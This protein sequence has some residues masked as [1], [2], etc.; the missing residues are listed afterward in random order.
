MEPVTQAAEAAAAR[1]QAAFQ[2]AQAA[3]EAAILKECQ[4][5][6]AACAALRAKNVAKAA[7]R[8]R[9]LEE[10]QAEIASLRKDIEHYEDQSDARELLQAFRK[11]AQVLRS[12]V[13]T[14][15]EENAA[16]SG[17]MGEE[18]RLAAQRAALPSLQQEAAK[19][20]SCAAE[21]EKGEKRSKL[22]HRCLEEVRGRL[23]I[24]KRRKAEMEQEILE[25]RPSFT[26]LGRQIEAAERER[27]WVH[28]ELDK[29]R[30]TSTGLRAEICQLREVRG[31]I[32]SVP[33][34]ED[35]QLGV[36]S[37]VGS[38]AGV[39][40]FATLQRRLAAVAPQ[41][42]PLC[43]RARAEMEELIQCCNRL[44]QRQKRLQQVAH[45]GIGAAAAGDDLDLGSI[46]V[47]SA[48]VGASRPQRARST[49]T[50]ISSAR[51]ASVAVSGTAS[52]AEQPGAGRGQ[53]RRASDLARSPLS[54]E[55]LGTRSARSTPRGSRAQFAS[56][57]A[58]TLGTHRESDLAGA[59]GDKE[60][61]H[62]ACSSR[63]P[64]CG[65]TFM[66]DSLFCRHCGQ[67]RELD[68]D[69]QAGPA[70]SSSS[71]EPSPRMPPSATPL[72]AN[73]SQCSQR[74]GQQA[75]GRTQADATKGYAKARTTRGKSQ[76]MA[77]ARS[78]PRAIAE[79]GRPSSS[80][81]V[82]GSCS[83]GYGGPQGAGIQSTAGT[84]H[85]LGL[86]VTPGTS[87]CVRGVQLVPDAKK[88]GGQKT[89]SRDRT[90]PGSCPVA[91]SAPSW[92]SP[93]GWTLRGTA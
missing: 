4:E 1:R 19:L 13:E 82:A 78:S 80:A 47:G 43:S 16:L 18:R 66:A 81:S 87:A 65:N 72:V 88:P 77:E 2:Q 71:R 45:G 44:E 57:S 51:G 79:P 31:A 40:R 28:G 75:S 15:R 14:L 17:S 58:S 49:D 73:G 91:Q 12:Q 32:D 42:M 60:A 92:K 35:L 8:R 68:Q 48:S 54:A 21:A 9:E 3:D 29:L 6:G 52:T 11:E 61:K 83:S 56:P 85:D 90:P 5:L 27:R 84:L 26:E 25:L 69:P 62:T 70:I 38:S 63:C 37:A 76:E 30:R 64:N 93:R 59:Q 20:R 39:E 36:E 7:R 22:V 74:Q 86:H 24:A 67:K 50:L 10:V 89:T 23:D 33:P 41:L 34:S 53:Q 46:S 55:T